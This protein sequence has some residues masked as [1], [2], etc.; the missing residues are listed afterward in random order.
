MIRS[1]FHNVPL[2]LTEF[3]QNAKS[4]YNKLVNL[5]VEYSLIATQCQIILFSGA[6]GSPAV[7]DSGEPQTDIKRKI[8][9]VLGNKYYGSA[10]ALH[11]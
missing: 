1:L 10:E 6:K 9:H 5:L 3:V 7:L 4:H 11:V 2:R 8:L